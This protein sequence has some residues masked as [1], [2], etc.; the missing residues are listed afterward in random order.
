M[1]KKPKS[2]WK[3]LGA[4]LSTVIVAASLLVTGA[5]SNASGSAPTLS[6]IPRLLEPDLVTLRAE[7][8]QGFSVGDYYYFLDIDGAGTRAKYEVIAL[9]NLRSDD[10]DFT[11]GTWE[12]DWTA[13]SPAAAAD[14]LRVRYKLQ[15]GSGNE[16]WVYDPPI[17]QA[18]ISTAVKTRSLA[19]PVVE[20]WRRYIIQLVAF[21][22]DV[23][24]TVPMAT[25]ADTALTF[26]RESDAGINRATFGPQSER[27]DDAVDRLDTDATSGADSK[28]LES[29]IRSKAAGEISATFKISFERL[30]SSTWTPYAFPYLSIN[31]YDLDNLQSIQFDDVSTYQSL[32][33]NNIQ[34]ITQVG[35]SGWKFLAKDINLNSPESETVGRIMVNFVNSSSVD[36]TYS[37]TETSALSSASFDLDMSTG[38]D[39]TGEAWTTSSGPAP[40]A[41]Q[42][43]TASAPPAPPVVAAIDVNPTNV[44]VD[45]E[46]ITILGAN[47]N[48]VTNVF[49]GGVSVPIFTQTGNRLQVRAPKGLSGPVDLELKSSLNDVLL[50]KKLNFGSTAAA[51][52]RKATLIVGGFAHNSRKL[53]AR[54]QDRID[55][56]L[57]RNSDLSTLTCTGFTSLP[58]R[59]TDVTL[60]TNRGLTACK[61]SKTERPELETSVSQG[62]EDPRPGSNVRRV[63][64]VL[65]P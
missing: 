5:P 62:I 24:A 52:T 51:G 20:E 43:Y 14:S 46:I 1:H 2:A 17:G 7:A 6:F 53:T 11:D 16:P 50:A 25:A 21:D 28:F 13:F 32:P 30:V 34:Q 3:K 8:M 36:F 26:L 15:D 38:F 29:V 44:T 45:N 59:T 61:F 65:T 42:E 58:R 4:V 47:L 54:M 18:G 55:R 23:S 10:D 39:F 9:E 31:V 48:T 56:W 35:A 37:S 41:P 19:L 33:G 57:E 12:L 60:S 49:I 63:R 27:I 40:V 64:L 22:D